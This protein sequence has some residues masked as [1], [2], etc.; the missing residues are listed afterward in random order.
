MSQVRIYDFLEGI[1][2]C[3]I[4]STFCISASYKVSSP[5][6]LA[7]KILDEAST[8]SHTKRC[9][10]FGSFQNFVTRKM[11]FLGLPLPLKAVHVGTALRSQTVHWIGAQFCVCMFPDARDNS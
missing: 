10:T 3:E 1:R 2:K 4:L 9:H 5:P 8:F 7:K 11:P 6:D